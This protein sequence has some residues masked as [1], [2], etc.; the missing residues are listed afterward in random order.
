MVTVQLKK[1]E[2]SFFNKLNDKA[3][4]VFTPKSYYKLREIF[5]GLINHRQDKRILD[6]G[7]GTGAFTKYLVEFNIPLIGIDLC[8]NLIATAQR[9]LGDAKFI[10]GDAEYLPLPDESIDIIVFSGFLHHLPDMKKAVKEAYR[11]LRKDG[12]CFA[13][14]PN[15]KNPIM[16]LYRSV[17]SPFYSH[18]GITSNERLLKSEELFDAFSKVGFKVEVFAI[19]GLF[20]RYIEDKKM[21]IFLP[22]YNTLER[23]LAI[24]PFSR[25]YGS[26]LITL[27]RK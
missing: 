7:C 1:E 26:F 11:V 22:I 17:H 9:K 5:A 24:T 19:S 15:G 20:Y 21:S 16:K 6:L 18:K 14:D 2:I 27:A 13:Y 25:I 3:Y 12:R 8:S 4:D 23:L 10:L